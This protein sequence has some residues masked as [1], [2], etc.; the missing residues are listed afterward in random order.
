M[1]GTGFFINRT[2]VLTNYHL[3]KGASQFRILTYDRNGVTDGALYTWSDEC[4]LAVVR[5]T[6]YYSK[7]VAG[8]VPD[9]NQER[10]GEVIYVVG[11]PEGYRASIS[12]GLLSAYRLNGAVM[13]VSAPIAQGSGGSPVFNEY[14]FVIGIIASRD[15]REQNLN[16][17]ISA[18]CIYEALKFTNGFYP[19]GHITGVTKGVNLQPDSEQPAPVAAPTPAPKCIDV[20]R[21]AQD[22]LTDR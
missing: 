20:N 11:N 15:V 9:S 22:A 6:S 12:G 2:D 19:K 14:G 13:Q 1:I 8:L 16:F 5:F 3:I 10:V 21:G 7:S 17:V 18:N 4:D